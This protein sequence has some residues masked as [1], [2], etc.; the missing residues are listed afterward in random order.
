MEPNGYIVCSRLLMAE[1][2][3]IEMQ[4][5]SPPGPDLV[6]Q[7]RAGFVLNGTTLGR[8]CREQHIPPQHARLALLGGWNGPKGSALRERLITVA[9]LHGGQKVAA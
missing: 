6:K 5:I 2:K 7:V 9:G 8:W 3:G 4:T 1:T